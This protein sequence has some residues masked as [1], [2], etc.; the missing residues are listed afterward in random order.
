MEP[1]EIQ[2]TPKVLAPKP[3]P[4][5]EVESKSVTRRR[6]VQ[7]E[8]LP[9]VKPRAKRVKIEVR[10]LETLDSL[11]D[12]SKMN[13]KEKTVYIEFLRGR[14]D[15]AEATAMA[16]A[17]NAESAFKMCRNAEAAYNSLYS[18]ATKALNLVCNGIKNLHD[19]SSMLP[20]LQRVETIFG[21]TPESTAVSDIERKCDNG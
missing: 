12:I 3:E 17:R 15:Q 18:S 13:D 7:T 5:P 14:R 4:T 16:Y 9:A 8:T 2:G 20:R 6:A 19:V 10:P 1:D 21:T 11:V